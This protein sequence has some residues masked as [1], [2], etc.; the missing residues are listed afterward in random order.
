MQ[1]G[2]GVTGGERGGKEQEQET[3]RERSEAQPLL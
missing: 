2:G 1:F 3:K